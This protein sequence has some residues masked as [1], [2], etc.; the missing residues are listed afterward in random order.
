MSAA[1][2]EE[3]RVAIAALLGKPGPVVVGAAPGASCSGPAYELAFE[4][5][6]LLRRRKLRHRVPISLLTTE[7]FLGHMGMGG[8]DK[9]R[10]LLEGALE[11]RDIAYATSAAV[12]Q[13]TLDA[14]EVDGA[15]PVP[16]VLSIVIPP[17]PGWR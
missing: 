15:A 8:S 13:I 9:I 11:E 5:D 12:T 1:E 3:L 4:L 10:Q 16:S 17:W 2:A 6:H 7:P 14:V